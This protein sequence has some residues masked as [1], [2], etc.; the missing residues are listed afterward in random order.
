MHSSTGFEKYNM[1]DRFYI[2]FT[3]NC[4]RVEEE[5]EQEEEKEDVVLGWGR[6]WGSTV[7]GGRLV[8]QTSLQKNNK[9]VCCGIQTIECATERT[10]FQ[11]GS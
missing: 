3:L 6:L 10:E 9:Y 8:L 11:Y 4:R 1:Y 7:Q 2:E 5:E